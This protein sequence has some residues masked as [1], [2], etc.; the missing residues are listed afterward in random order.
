MSDSDSDP[1]EQS[2]STVGLVPDATGGHCVTFSLRDHLPHI[3]RSHRRSSDVTNATS[4]PGGPAPAKTPVHR[5][6]SGGGPRPSSSAAAVQHRPSAAGHHLNGPNGILR[7]QKG[8]V[9]SSGVDDAD[10]VSDEHAPQAHQLDTINEDPASPSSPPVPCTFT[11]G[12]ASP[13]RAATENPLVVSIR[14]QLA[15]E[16]RGVDGGSGSTAAGGGE[17][18]PPADSS[19]MKILDRLGKC[20]PCNNN[21]D[22]AV[23]PTTESAKV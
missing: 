4:H 22:M 15:R 23:N 17:S 21:G 13:P 10:S 20:A 3:P 16:L 11:I 9:D 1:N 7:V 18:A 8:G 5:I 19:E 12:S 6:N 2:D 14:E